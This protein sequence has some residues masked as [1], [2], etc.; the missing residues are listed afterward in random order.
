MFI[1][2]DYVR[3]VEILP[4]DVTHTPS[5]KVSSWPSTSTNNRV[6]KTSKVVQSSRNDNQDYCN[7]RL[8]CSRF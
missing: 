3:T 8:V 6:N 2:Y 7:L 5:S 1:L 4:K